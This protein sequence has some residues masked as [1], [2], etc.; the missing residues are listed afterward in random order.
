MCVN[1]LIKK[2]LMILQK[3]IEKSKDK[4]KIKILNLEK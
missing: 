4:I 1:K 2:L 3:K